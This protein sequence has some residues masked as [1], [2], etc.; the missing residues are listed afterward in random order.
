[1][2]HVYALARCVRGD[3]RQSRAGGTRSGEVGGPDRFDRIARGQ[4]S[5]FTALRRACFAT[6][7]TRLENESSLAELVAGGAEGVALVAESRALLRS[8]NESRDQSR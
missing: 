8:E 3:D 1:M 6:L 5:V 7:R 2:E 4:Q